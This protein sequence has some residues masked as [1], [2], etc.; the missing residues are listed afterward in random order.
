M[1]NVLYNKRGRQGNLTTPRPSFYFKAM[2]RVAKL[3]ITTKKLR[4]R[5][6]IS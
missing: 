6:M 5:L 3:I 1:M 2:M 4:K